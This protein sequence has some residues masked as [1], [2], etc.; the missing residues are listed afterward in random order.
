ML[1]HVQGILVKPGQVHEPAQE[2]YEEEKKI[3]KA[4]QAVLELVGFYP[5]YES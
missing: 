4:R 3:R 5:T 1:I 2:R